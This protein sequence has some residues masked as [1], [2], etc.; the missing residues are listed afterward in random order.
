MQ[1]VPLDLSQRQEICD[2]LG[3]KNR[4]PEGE[5]CYKSVGEFC[6]GKPRSLRKMTGDGNCLFRALCYAVTGAQTGHAK[7]RQLVTQHIRDVGPINGLDASDYLRST[8]MESDTTY[9]TEIELFAAADLFQR[10]I[11]VY[12]PYNSKDNCKWLK[13]DCKSGR[14]GRQAIFLDNRYGTG[15][16]GHFNVVLSI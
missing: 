3:L 9:G 10:D 2:R 7:V 13:H 8:D 1:F 12:H 5:L 6:D 14:D 15:T 11:Y 4:K 16:D